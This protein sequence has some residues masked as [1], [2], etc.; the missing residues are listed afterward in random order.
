MKSYLGL[1]G[2]G[3]REEVRLKRGLEE[4]GMTSKVGVEVW[5]IKG[6]GTEAETSM[7]SS[8]AVY[9]PALKRESRSESTRK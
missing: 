3:V 1:E 2:E 7:V 9:R 6:P 4:S 8:E 5:Q